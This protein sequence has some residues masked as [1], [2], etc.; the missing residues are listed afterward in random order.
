MT[1]PVLL[2]LVSVFIPEDWE[3]FRS[4]MEDLS[5]R[6]SGVRGPAA[7]VLYWI[8]VQELVRELALHRLECQGRTLIETTLAE[9]LAS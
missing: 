1:G 4:G 5:L 6:Y 2:D 9:A 7:K 3:S 8:E